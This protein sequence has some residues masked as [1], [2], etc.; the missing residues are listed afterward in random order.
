MDTI[1]EFPMTGKGIPKDAFSDKE[2]LRE[3]RRR[4][5][6]VLV[7]IV[8]L[9]RVELD[10]AVVE[11]ED[12]RVR[13]VAIGIR[14]IALIHLCHQALNFTSRWKRNYM[15]LTLNLIWQ[16]PPFGET[17]TRRGQAVSPQH[18]TLLETVVS[19]TLV[20]SR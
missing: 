10:L 14:I 2:R 13:E 1:G 4:G 19:M 3:E 6:V 11:V 5:T 8:D 15:L 7:G 16:H 12:R 9:V 20:V 18:N 17:R